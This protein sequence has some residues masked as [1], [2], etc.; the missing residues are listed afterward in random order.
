M[1]DPEVGAHLAPSGNN[2]EAFIAG[3]AWEKENVVKVEMIEH[4]RASF[5][6]QLR[7]W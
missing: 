6:K 7:P 4:P 1:R 3:A 2:E 5:V